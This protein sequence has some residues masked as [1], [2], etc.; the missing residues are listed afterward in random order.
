M[1]LQLLNSPILLRPSSSSSPPTTRSTKFLNDPTKP[2]TLP[3]FLIR[4]AKRQNPSRG[5]QKQPD[6]DLSRILRT[7]AAIN[8]IERKANSN[9]YNQLW[10][11]AV[12]DA[13]D[14]AIRE[15]QWESALKIFRLLRKQH[16]YEPR[17]QTYTKL[18]VMLGKCRQPKQ[19]GFLFELIHSDGLEPTV[20]VYTALVSAYGLSGLLDEAFHTLDLMKS[21]SDCRPDVYT[22]SILINCCMKLHRF[23]FVKGILAEMSY[24]GVECSAVT[25]N[26]IIDGYGK[27]K[28]FEP[29]E[30]SLTDMIESDACNPD[31]FTLNSFIGTYGNCGKIVEMEKWFEEFQLMGIGPDIKTFN[32][33][34]KSYGKAGMYEKMGSVLE[35][36]KKRFFSP[37]VVTFNTVIEAFGR[38]GN[39]EKMEEFFLKMKHQGMKPTS[40][41][42]CTLVSAYSK[43]GLL[44]RIDSI[45]R[46][47]EN[48][49]V[50]LDTA[51]FNC[52][53]SAYGR[54][55]NI[56]RMGELLL[57]MKERNC[58]LDNITLATLI[59]AY[60]KQGMI[61]AVK[62]LEDKMI[63]DEENSVRMKLIGC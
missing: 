2:S 12:L 51:F 20:D 21:V 32:I 19:A 63:S 4:A 13:L 5:L 6:K 27:A 60:K 35:F 61:E 34:I 54:A 59:Q 62:E 55:G 8:A 37:T 16:W 11:K 24:L 46:Q 7:E 58:K 56:K 17:C 36:M 45:M 38:S 9:K 39:I 14:E 15:N 30:N 49:D 43:S 52:V 3:L 41:T 26:T 44:H 50:V 29:M 23:H 57:T 1:N 48:S 10:P 31:V 18:L 25:Y 22:Y 40:V 53:I 33:L 42:Y 28:L 47:V